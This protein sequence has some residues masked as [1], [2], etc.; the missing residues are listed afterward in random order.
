MSG[1]GM[2][3][4]WAAAGSGALSVAVHVQDLLK[5]VVITLIDGDGENYQILKILTALSML[6][7]LVPAFKSQPLIFV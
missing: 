6:F 1:R 5:E 4:Q 7:Y 2:G 3:Q